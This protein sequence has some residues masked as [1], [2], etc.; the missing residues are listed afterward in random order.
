[1]E[2]LK[3]FLWAMF[4]VISFF[5]ACLFS[6]G[7][8]DEAT[9]HKI[10][11]NLSY[12]YEVRE[13]DWLTVEGRQV[14]IAWKKIPGDMAGV[15]NAAAVNANRNLEGRVRVYSID[16][17]RY[18]QPTTSLSSVNFYCEAV[19]VDGRLNEGCVLKYKR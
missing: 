9:T 16:A 17:N 15:I 13:I 12:L 11:N 7:C 5:I 1:M 2:R 10:K 4:I 14:I 19:A 18:P 3:S 8:A 6:Q